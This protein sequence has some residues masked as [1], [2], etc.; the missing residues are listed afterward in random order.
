MAVSQGQLAPGSDVREL[1]ADVVKAQSELAHGLPNQA[2]RILS[3]YLESHPE[4]PN[5]RLTLGEAWLM[6]GHT[7]RAEAEFQAVLKISPEDP[8]AL[9]ALGS[10][11]DRAGHPDKAEPFLAR[12]VKSSNWEARARVQWAAVLARIHRYEEADRALAGLS[13]TEPAQARVDFYRLKGSVDLGLGKPKAAAADMETALQL[14]PDNPVL[15]LAT[16]IVEAQAGNWER[17]VRL[18]E[19]LYAQNRDPRVG[20]AFLEAQLAK[21]EDVHQ[22]LSQ[23]R[24]TTLPREQE[25]AFREQ[26]AAMLV[27]HGHYADAVGDLSKAAEIETSRPD[28]FFN[29]AL[30]HLKAGQL[31]PALAAAQKAKNLGDN[32]ELEDL[33]G[34]I[35]EA[36]GD[37]LAAVRSYQAAVALA[38]SQE[39][40][41][42]PLAMELISHKNFE[43]AEV[44]LRQAGQLFPTSWRIQLALGVTNFLA[45]QTEEAT[46]VLLHA[47]DLTPDSALALGYLGEMQVALTTTPD[48]T[49]LERL[50]HF[51]DRHPQEGKILSYCGALLLQ[52]DYASGDKTHAD[53][54]LRR[55][56]AARSLQP[57]DALPHCQLGKMY[58]WLGKWGEALQETETCTHL[59]P[60][61]AEAHYRLARLYTRL[62]HPDLAR[63]EFE[64]HVTAAERR[65][66]E[67]QRRDEVLKT[68]LYTLRNQPS[69]RD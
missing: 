34:D 53:Q 22:T 37:N 10:L 21:H 35:Q 41:R 40:Y 65:T 7:D 4:D 63:K 69:G 61:S 27:R 12:A 60:E 14:E 56:L 36:R 43:A 30:A 19:P 47:A 67:N 5:A 13:P 8:A 39:E 1:P 68:F 52:R 62:G 17:S 59:N 32:A 31:E 29:L 9:M 64:L 44:V 46:R 58:E 66:E 18:L 54:I 55:L 50:C 15:Q 48:P 33:L 49:A 26:L 24:K 16:G 20:L 28:L 51:S 6:A 23:L 57:Q 42:L 38:P 11:Y 2:I 3:S 25:A 45:G